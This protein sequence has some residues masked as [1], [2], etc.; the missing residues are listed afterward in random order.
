M[1]SWSAPVENGGSNI[2]SYSLLIRSSDQ[3]T[4]VTEL[5]SCNGWRSSVVSSGQCEIP[6]SELLTS[7][8]DL[9]W[10]S[11]VVAKLIAT[12]IWGNSAESAAG[13]GAFLLKVGDAPINL[14]E[15]PDYRT[16]TTLALSWENGKSSGGIPVLDYRVTLISP[17]KELITPGIKPRSIIFTDLTPGVTYTISVE[18]YNVN[19]YSRPSAP[20]SLLC[21]YKP[22]APSA[23]GSSN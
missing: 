22:F 20:L 9:T 21:A 8:F 12:N 18:A 19:G 3:S 17:G 7:P 16:A 5:E 15:L 4:Y 2:S 10:G 1:V 23:I 11:E 14:K 13:G 6:T